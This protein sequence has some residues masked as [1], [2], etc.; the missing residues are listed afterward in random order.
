MSSGGYQVILRQ[1]LR[2]NYF[3]EIL[4]W[5]SA[6]TIP[7]VGVYV[8]IELMDHPTVLMSYKFQ[9]QIWLTSI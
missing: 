6:Q 1:F 5:C 4:L 8:F 3:A 7:R 2:Q 9:R